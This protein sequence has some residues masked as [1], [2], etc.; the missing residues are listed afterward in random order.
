[1]N[2]IRFEGNFDELRARKKWLDAYVGKMVTRLVNMTTL[3]LQKHI[4]KD[5]FVEYQGTQRNLF[6]GYLQTRSGKL[7]KSVI[8][9]PAKRDG[10]VVRGGIG[11]GTK[12]GHVQFGKRGQV[13]TI[14][15]KRA[16]ALTIPLPAAMNAQGVAK[17]SARDKSI[18]G[19]TFLA[20]SESG[21]MIIFG[22]TLYV[23]GKK[24]GQAKGKIVPLFVL[25]KS[26]RVPARIHP[27]DLMK[28]V[29]PLLGKG[30]QDIKAGLAGATFAEETP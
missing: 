19:E 24:A 13:T 3:A 9:I 27:D 10:D 2:E 7:K 12:Y 1:M 14:T 16:G 22:K 8:N 5:L 25:K 20:K 26:V 11:I 29:Q 4:R 21:N 30:F 23:K 17:G 15:P 18:F 28:F 6:T